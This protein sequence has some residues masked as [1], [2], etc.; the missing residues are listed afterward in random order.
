MEEVENII[1]QRCEEKHIEFIVDFT[2][3]AGTTVTGDKLRLKQVL[4]NLLGNAVKFTP[5]RG[6]IRF[7]ADRI[8]GNEKKVKVHFR[9]SDSGIGMKPEQMAN[10]F[11]AFEQADASI[12]A[13]FGGTGLGLAISQ[14]L[15]KQMGGLIT[16]ESEYGKGSAFQFALDMD[17]SAAMAEE[18]AQGAVKAE[19]PGKRI[20]LAEDIE[21]NRMIIKE[22]L[23][24][25]RVIIDEAADGQEALDIFSASAPGYYNLVFMD[26]QMPN[27]DGHEA[28]RRIRALDREDAKTI[29]IIAMTANAYREDID[30][31]LAAG[32]NDHLAKP[33]D[34]AEV[35]KALSKWLG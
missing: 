3:I 34:I 12:S 5:D 4:I 1:L 26:V 32:M 21:I 16:V 35:T 13:R 27:M 15:I 11:T 2:G 19:F 6:R 8:G 28:T 30:R 31:A 20:L 23:S 9:V 7:S 18:A 22:L 24:D 33:I 25:T 17:T 10:L 14:N 29:P